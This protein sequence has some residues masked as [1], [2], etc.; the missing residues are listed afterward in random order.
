[1]FSTHAELAKRTGPYG[2]GRF[3]FLQS[4]VTEYQDITS[5]EAKFQVLAN[6]A[7][8]A[9]DPINYEYLRQ[10]N[11]IDLFLDCLSES[12]PKLVEFAIGGI[13]NLCLDKI[14]KQYILDNDGVKLICH[15][16]SSDNEETVLSAITALMYLVTPESKPI[17]TTAQIIDAM[18]RFSNSKNPRVSNLASVFVSDYCSPEDV[19]HAVAVTEQL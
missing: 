13:C 9:Y 2:V 19:A 12:D 15:C 5:H 18:L 11:V 17:I 1:M 14:N 7:N 8:F 10:L 3:S 4:L 16:L 6:L